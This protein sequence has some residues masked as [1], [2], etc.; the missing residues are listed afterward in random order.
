[1]KEK[2]MKTIAS[3]IDKAVSNFENEKI[4]NELQ[5]EVK[6]FTSSFPLFAEIK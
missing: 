6:K 1:M 4:L 3:I 5:Q 2:A